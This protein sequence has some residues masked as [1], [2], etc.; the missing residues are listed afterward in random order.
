MING[1]ETKALS[2]QWKSPESPRPKEAGQSRTNVKAMLTVF[3]FFHE[4]VEHH[5]YVPPG[6]T[7]YKEYY[8]ELASPADRC[9]KKKAAAAVGK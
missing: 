6:H 3:F 5:E 8:I 7:I 2:S 9:S 1:P 4:G